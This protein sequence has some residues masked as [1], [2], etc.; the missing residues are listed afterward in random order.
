MRRSWLNTLMKDFMKIV[1]ESV[2]V[3]EGILDAT[4]KFGA[5]AAAGAALLG[6]PSHAGDKDMSRM[7]AAHAKLLPQPGEGNE[8]MSPMDDDYGGAPADAPT[9]YE[10]RQYLDDEDE[11][12]AEKAQEINEAYRAFVSSNAFMSEAALSE[13]DDADFGDL[14]DG[15]DEGGDEG[16]EDVTES[17]KGAGAA[18][19]FASLALIGLAQI[20]NANL[21]R[22]DREK[23]QAAALQTSDAGRLAAQANPMPNV[24]YVRDR[25]SELPT[26]YAHL[27]GVRYVDELPGEIREDWDHLA[28]TI[29]GE[30]RGQSHADMTNIAN[31]IRNRVAEGRW[32][33]SYTAVVTAPRQ[34]SCWNSHDPNYRPMHEMRNLDH[35]LTH[36]YGTTKYQELMGEVQN[37]PD[38]KAWVE[39]KAIAWKIISN[40]QQDTTGGAD[41][42]HTRAVTPRWDS[43]MEVTKADDAHVFSRGA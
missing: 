30:G 13:E 41:H 11:D 27:R 26:R 40:R 32:G 10:S 37:N 38:F 31:S 20:H 35:R 6:I 28:M 5:A 21:D 8:A 36:L 7:N 1:N 33:D 39:A 24:V 12:A 25:N 42:Y 2:D 3:D 18:T 19:A 14:V 17:F 34:F 29:W 9:T 15:G 43:S 16:G 4:R 23:E 22:Q